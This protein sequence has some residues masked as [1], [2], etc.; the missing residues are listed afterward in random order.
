[1]A[2]QAAVLAKIQTNVGLPY[3][4]QLNYDVANKL[5]TYLV[6]LD[7][8]FGEKNHWSLRDNITNF[9]TTNSSSTSTFGLNE[10][11]E[12]DKFYQL[13]LEGDTVI[14]NNIFN[15]FIGQYARDQRP[16]TATTTG[17][18]FTINYATSTQFFGTADTTPNTADE[19]KYQLKDTL[20][21][22]WHGQSLKVGGEL[23]H[24]QL[25]DSFPRFA[26]GQ[27][28]FTGL[29]NFVNNFA[30]FFQQAYGPQNGDVAWDTSL[31]GLYVNDSF[32]VGP[33]LTI[34]AGVRYDLEKTPRPPGNA[35]PLHPEFLTQIKDDTNNIGPR[36]GFAYDV[37]GNGRSVLRGGSGK[38]FEYM[39]DIL[40]A[41]PIQGISGALIT[42]TFTCTTTATNPCPTYPNILSP[43]DFLAKAKLGANL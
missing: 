12:V 7:A 5:N 38:F 23:L 33:R 10:T 14:T 2:Q 39:P 40:L 36:L 22:Q 26:G 8:N 24:R 4:S 42:S 32:H 27:Y 25:F 17:T 9:N 21:Y 1:A 15:Q 13:A 43:A 20:N 28:Q 18:E 29:T 31:W 6:K 30:G 3:E 11:D 37:L 19:K 41:S 16:V 35:Y 34:D